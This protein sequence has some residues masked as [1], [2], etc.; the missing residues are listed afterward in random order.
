MK[1]DKDRIVK[2][3]RPSGNAGSVYVPRKWVNKRVI[4]RLLEP[5]RPERS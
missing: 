4:V 3:V 1:K 5:E 2:E